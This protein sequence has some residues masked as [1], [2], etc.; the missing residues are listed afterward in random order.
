MKKLVL[1]LLIPLTLNAE[2]G[3]PTGL[4]FS[5]QLNRCLTTEAA[6]RVKQSEAACMQQEGT[7]RNQCFEQAAQNAVAEKEASGEIS[8][9]VGKGNF[10]GNKI[11]S[12]ALNGFALG[13]AAVVLLS[14][15]ES[16]DC[17]QAY[18]LYA[19]G[20]GAI[21]AALGEIWTSIQYSGKL[22]DMKKR[23]QTIEEDAK[24]SNEQA[25]A[26]DIQAQAFQVMADQQSLIAEIA[27]AKKGWYTAAFVAYTASTA[28]SAFEIASTAW[29]GSLFT[30][31]KN[32]YATHPQNALPSLEARDQYLVDYFE[33][34][35]K[36]T[37]ETWLVELDKK[38]AYHFNPTSAEELL[39]QI[40]FT[41]K[42]RNSD[43]YAINFDEYDRYLNV[44]ADKS[45]LGSSLKAFNGLMD[46]MLFPKAFAQASA[47]YE[48]RIKG[49]TGVKCDCEKPGQTGS[50]MTFNYK[51]CD[52]GI[53]DLK[54]CVGAKA[55]A[56]GGKIS[57]VDAMNGKFGAKSATR[58]EDSRSKCAKYLEKKCTAKI[59]VLEVPKRVAEV[60]V[61]SMIPITPIALESL[62][63]L[64]LLPEIPPLKE[65]K[66]KIEEATKVATAP[67]YG[68]IVKFFASPYTRLVMGGLMAAYSKAT[69]DHYDKQADVAKSRQ[70][71]IEKLKTQVTAAGTEFGCSNRD[72]HTNP[73][74]YCYGESGELNPAR[75]KSDVCK[76]LF[77]G[78]PNL[79]SKNLANSTTN[80]SKICMSKSS[81]D[82]GCSCVA[83][84]TC[85][86]VG[87]T[88]SKMPPSLINSIM[89]AQDMAN[90]LMSGALDAAEVSNFNTG[91]FASRIANIKDVIL[92]KNP[93]AKTNIEKAR[94]NV[95]KLKNH[96]DRQLASISK[97]RLNGNT[98]PTT[99]FAGFGASAPALDG[100]GK[101]DPK[102]VL[103]SLNDSLYN[104]ASPLNGVTN[105][106]AAD[107]FSL[108]DFNATGNTS[109]VEVKEEANMAEANFEYNMNDIND[110]K[111]SN[112]FDILSN[113]YQTTGMEK[114]FGDKG[115][116]PE[117]FEDE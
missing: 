111:S 13:G 39:F 19:L 89:P 25:S 24:K 3:C 8:K 48:T 95:G 110:D 45:P 12:L 58:A 102:D 16:A 46:Q 104:P 103:K 106:S 56:I 51:N 32:L 37:Y 76:N 27:K 35:N 28:L 117:A 78:K 108:D 10:A 87:L 73:S 41:M 63:S 21:V 4:S 9:N 15:Q 40:S 86:S 57:S 23:F 44:I 5:P 84:K 31:C 6:S 30:E 107:N 14:S 74:C 38:S 80:K 17:N 94:N 52:F 81:L 54:S 90:G 115:F 75:S 101:A 1:L 11:W 49:A 7:A 62:K 71:A 61:A 18:S 82:M 47:A 67:V 60:A 34:M 43:I 116:D 33:N 114:L 112:I 97:G 88:S 98:Y 79:N 2:T 92:A 26:T 53:E 42:M 85:M 69:L 36:V 66:L 20:G 91:L 50:Q 105:Q 100:L 70:S 77:G 99:G 22:D 96:L 29:G 93:K 64:K 83:T 72:D 68:G 55:G 113:R 59:M 65:F 109:P